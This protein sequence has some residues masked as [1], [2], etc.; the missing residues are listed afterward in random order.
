MTPST[1]PHA[2]LNSVFSLQQCLQNHSNIEKRIHTSV[3]TGIHLWRV[4]MSLFNY[5]TWLK[6]Y[7]NKQ[8]TNYL[9]DLTSIF[10]I[11]IAEGYE[12]KLMKSNPKI[13]RPPIHGLILWKP[14]LL[15]KEHKF[16]WT[17]GFSCYVSLSGETYA[18]ITHSWHAQVVFFRKKKW[19]DYYNL[20]L[21]LLPILPLL[22]TDHDFEQVIQILSLQALSHTM[23]QIQ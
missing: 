21:I 5:D 8:R 7:E 16:Q 6:N 18:D 20:V 23:R 15:F 22:S 14:C 17:V 9:L 11:A 19:D 12:R 2:L 4:C 1:R 3:N 13:Q 10:K